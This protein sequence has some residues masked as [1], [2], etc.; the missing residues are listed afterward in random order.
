MGLSRTD[1]PPPPQMGLPETELAS[2]RNPWELAQG[3]MTDDPDQ[4]QGLGTSPMPSLPHQAWRGGLVL[5]QL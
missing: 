2:R 1:P 4:Q 5:P 3:L